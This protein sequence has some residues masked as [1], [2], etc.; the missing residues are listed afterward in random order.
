[1]ILEFM[2]DSLLHRNGERQKTLARR[3]G[4]DPSQ[5][6]DTEPGR[7]RSPLANS[8]AQTPCLLSDHHSHEI[9]LLCGVQ[10]REHEASF[11]Q[12]PE[13]QEC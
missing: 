6:C 9:Q 7:H 8:S 12:I 5:R 11:S 10:N 1:M 2:Q 4:I 13:T 3:L